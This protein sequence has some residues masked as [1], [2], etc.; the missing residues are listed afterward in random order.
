MTL[1]IASGHT[2]SPESQLTPEL[3]K[4]LDALVQNN[5]LVLI[6]KGTPEE[7]QCGFSARAVEV[8]KAIGQPF[9]HVNVFDREDP[10]AF[11]QAVGEWA[12]WPTLP[13]CWV[14]GELIGGSDIALE[15]YQNGEIK[16]MLDE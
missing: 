12:D 9:A 6:M 1:P 4:E 3:K 5:D 7:P 10:M 2:G 13:Q 15:M 11:I 8:Y 14:K 16:Q